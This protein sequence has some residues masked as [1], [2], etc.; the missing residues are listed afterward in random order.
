MHVRP[1]E[2]PLLEYKEYVLQKRLLLYVPP[3]LLVLGVVG[4]LLS[5]II[6]M[7]R[8]MRGCSTYLYLAVL[9][10]TDTLVLIVGLLRLWVGELTGYD[11]RDHTNGMCK[12]INVVG[13]TISIYSVWLIVAVTVERYVAICY[14]LQSLS[15]CNRRRACHVILGL[16][17]TIFSINMHL[18]WTAQVSTF[19]IDGNKYLSCDGGKNYAFLVD[20][21]WPWVDAGLYSFLPSGVILVL[22]IL[23]IR[24]VVAARRNRSGLVSHG[25]PATQKRNN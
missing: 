3:I 2:E 4:N 7:R 15:L 8:S 25:F 6:L 24:N 21:V 17:I 9:S 13:Y 23:I 19:T 18:V 14:P 16:L 1:Y 20:V 10:I 11:P 5:F 22:N 12:A